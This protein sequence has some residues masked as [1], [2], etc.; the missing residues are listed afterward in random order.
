ML[1]HFDIKY[2]K[3]EIN[4]KIFEVSNMITEYMS[5]III[6]ESESLP[7]WK[8]V[9][10]YKARVL[11]QIDNIPE[12][13]EIF[14]KYINE[15]VLITKDILSSTFEKPVK[16]K[17]VY[18]QKWPTGSY[19]VKHNDMYNFD[20]TPLFLDFKLATTLYM[21][22]NFTGGKLEFPDHN[23]SISPRQGS[24][25]MFDG[26]P[27]NEHQVTEIE[28]GDR[29][30]IVSFWDIEGSRYTEEELNMSIKNQEKWASQNSQKVYQ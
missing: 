4:S 6:E 22:N 17:T 5:R 13:S 21:H 10:F 8:N 1:E 11:E 3:N 9:G 7:G 20:G 18:I 28:S 30:T 16:F 12:A 27:E 25:Y 14:K 19:A 2:F 15:Y 24:A 26:G 23:I 29:Y